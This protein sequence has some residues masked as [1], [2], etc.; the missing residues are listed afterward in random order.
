ME[1]TFQ[2]GADA[3]MEAFCDAVETGSDIVSNISGSVGSIAD[4]VGTLVTV[5]CDLFS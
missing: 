2:S 5:G 1:I 3:F 4:G